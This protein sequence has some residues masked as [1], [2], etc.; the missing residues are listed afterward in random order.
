MQAQ[1]TPYMKLT[2]TPGPTL[3]GQKPKEGRIQPQSLGKG[4]LKHNKLKKKKKKGREIL[5]K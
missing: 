4:D 1:V 5:H 2:Q 3:Q